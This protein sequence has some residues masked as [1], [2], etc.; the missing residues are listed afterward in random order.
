MN[1]KK[2][3]VQYLGQKYGGGVRVTLETEQLFTVSVPHD[4]ADDQVDKVDGTG[5][6]QRTRRQ[7]FSYVDDKAS[8]NVI[9][10]YVKRKETPA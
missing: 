6:F 9:A 1:T 4:W 7:N 10:E 3:I 8:E 2:T 5:V